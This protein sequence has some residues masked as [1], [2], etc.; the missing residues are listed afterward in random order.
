MNLYFQLVKILSVTNDVDRL[1]DF[2]N[3]NFI[4]R[5]WMIDEI[6]EDEV[7]VLALPVKK[8]G[9]FDLKVEDRFQ[10]LKVDSKYSGNL[11]TRELLQE[12]SEKLDFIISILMGEG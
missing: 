2:C 3:I 1:I 5:G 10:Y 11:S 7:E 9:T 8:D 4:E 6:S 12:N